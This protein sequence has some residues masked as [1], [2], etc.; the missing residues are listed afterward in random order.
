MLAGKLLSNIGK[1]IQNGTGKVLL[2]IILGLGL[3][4]L[5]RKSCDDFNCIIYRG[6]DY[7]NE[8]KDKTF[9]YNKKC[10]QY[11]IHPVSCGR[12]ENLINM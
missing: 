7:D 8:V 10:Y 11:Q 5:F 4:S 2:S 9:S 1:L 3:A 12:E 6:I